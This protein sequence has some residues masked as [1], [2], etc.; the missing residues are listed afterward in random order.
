MDIGTI[1]QELL[2]QGQNPE[3]FD[4]QVFEHGYSI[5]PKWFHE[6]KKIAKKEDKPIIEDVNDVAITTAFVLEDNMTVA[7]TLAITLLEIENLKTEIA[8]L[9]GGDK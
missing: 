3:D 6:T 9:K 5:T 4:I 2:K 8:L 7:E 1:K